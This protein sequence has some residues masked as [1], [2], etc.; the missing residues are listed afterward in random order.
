MQLL[1]TRQFP[2]TKDLTKRLPSPVF[3]I[4]GPVMNKICLCHTER[5]AALEPCF[6]WPCFGEDVSGWN[7]AEHI[8]C[9]GE[10]L[11]RPALGWGLQV[12]FLPITSRK[13]DSH[14]QSSYER[15]HELDRPAIQ[16]NQI[17]DN[18]Q[19]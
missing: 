19:P 9:N 11:Y 17:P 4:R 3:A 14:P 6:G 5:I 18:R 8:M 12:R 10:T 13:R 16:L 2:E 7:F 15:I 1:N